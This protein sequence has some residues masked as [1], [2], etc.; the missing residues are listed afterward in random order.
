MHICEAYQLERCI[1]RNRKK[2]EDT[3]KRV[4]KEIPYEMD[5]EFNNTE[6]RIY[7][8]LSDWIFSNKFDR[9][10]FNN[11]IL[12]LIWSFFSSSAAFSDELKNNPSVPNE[13]RELTASWISDDLN[14]INN[15]RNILDDPMDSMSRMVTICD[16]LEQEAYDKKVLIFT[17]FSG[18]HRL[19]RQLLTRV[20]GDNCCTFFSEG[21]TP[22]ELELNTY[23]FQN[24]SGY[25]IMLSDESGGEGRNFQIADE[26]ICLDLPWS[27][28]TLEQR[29]G[30]LD[31]IGRDKTKDVVSVIVYAQDSV[32][33]D[34]A[35]IW[36]KGLNIFS[37]SQ[38][39]LEIIM[40][41]IDEQIRTA[42]MNDFKYGLSSIVDEMVG[43][44][45][46]I[47]KQV[48]EERH[49]DIATYTYQYT[50]KEIER[51]VKRNNENES[52]LFRNS[53]MSWSSLAGFRGNSV[54]D[55]IV[56]F[57][58]SS[59]SPKS[60]YNTMFVPPDMDIMIKDR[61]NQMQN[62]IRSLNGDKAIQSDINSI[63]GTFD[64]NLAL[65]N[66]YLH[67]FA[68]GDGIFDSIVNNAVSAYKG[69][70]AAFALECSMDWEGFVFNWYIVPDELLLLKSGISLKQ[71]NQYR[72]FLSSEI[73]S[74]YISIDGI[75]AGTDKNII[76]EFKKCFDFPINELKN[77]FANFGKRTPSND[78]LGIKGKYAI[79]NL[80]WFR[81]THSASQWITAVTTCYNTAKKQAIEEFRKLNRIKALN[82]TLN[83]E[84]C[85]V[86]AAAAYFG[87]DIDSIEKMRSNEVV[88]EAFSKPNIVLDSVCYVRMINL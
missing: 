23:R 52:E 77:Y 34:L 21:M 58:A 43:E 62:H 18:T 22:D 46:K 17:H 70:C 75:N 15:I 78:F 39:G 83:R 3:N 25:R 84:F 14:T 51:T 33:K 68:P 4:L 40:N 26:L 59:F 38:S 69:R 44:I 31:R 88:L 81:E 61:L 8:L 20:F 56:R 36:N 73:I 28:N 86:C 11:K 35:D 41:D 79:S 71:V 16:Y 19:F 1:I 65:G 74:T 72:G 87:R 48:K 24:E 53:M 37:K 5:T 7:S 13:I 32:E 85:S 64:R 57:N 10:D 9:K 47:E 30:R 82:D 60:A 29:I 42:V 54:S 63:Q 80:S 27:A 55:N 76:Q 50:N 12:P 66:D 67:F 45:K 49:F 2:S 6:Y